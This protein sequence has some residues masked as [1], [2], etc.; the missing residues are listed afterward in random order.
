MVFINGVGFS[1]MSCEALGAHLVKILTQGK[2]NALLQEV[3]EYGNYVEKVYLL[4]EFRME[5][6][7]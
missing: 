3:G 1:W 7:K 5:E 2:A 4:S 6:T